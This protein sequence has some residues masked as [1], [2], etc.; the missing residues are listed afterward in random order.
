MNPASRQRVP[1]RKIHPHKSL[2]SPP[3]PLQSASGLQGMCKVWRTRSQQCHWE[4]LGR[5]GEDQ[6][7]APPRRLDHRRG[8]EWRH[9]MPP[10]QARSDLQSK[11][12]WMQVRCRV[13]LHQKRLRPS[14]AS[15][16]K[17]EKRSEARHQGRDGAKRRPPLLSSTRCNL[18]KC[19]AHRL[20]P[21]P[22]LAPENART[23]TQSARR[24]TLTHGVACTALSSQ[25]W[26]RS[27]A[28]QRHET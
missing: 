24:Q 23:S 8:F 1:S 5:L 28:H 3:S 9:Q 2:Q 12:W 20:R 27:A 19:P 16:W 25:S 18:P 21:H 7:S 22:Q 13:R 10:S 4:S 11:C 15:D 6:C 14:P 26:S 17:C